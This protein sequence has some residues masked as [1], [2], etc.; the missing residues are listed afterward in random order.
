M[1]E[2]HLPY[3]LALPLHLRVQLRTRHYAPATSLI[4]CPFS[5]LWLPPL[6]SFLAAWLIGPIL[7]YFVEI[8]GPIVFY[9]LILRFNQ[10]FWKFK[11]VFWKFEKFPK[12]SPA[13][14]L[15]MGEAREVWRLNKI[16][17]K[18]VQPHMESLQ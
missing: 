1:E 3:D 4:N 2:G 5:L 17:R 13:E 15:K 14:T 11:K 18:L 6:E 7:D 8:V 12:C 16:L 9:P 10:V